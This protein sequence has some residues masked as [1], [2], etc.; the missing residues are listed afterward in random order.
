MLCLDCREGGKLDHIEDK[1]GMFDF[2]ILLRPVRSYWIV[3]VDYV[4]AIAT[5]NDNNQR[6]F[7]LGVIRM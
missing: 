2:M 1:F 7:F 4:F 5:A 3:F 6:F